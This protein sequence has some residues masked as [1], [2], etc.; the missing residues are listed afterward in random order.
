MYYVY[1]IR[2]ISHPLEKYVG[3]TENL[4]ARIGKHNEGGSPHT[5]SHRPW[6]P[7]A[8]LAFEE[9]STAMAF[10][11]YLKTGSGRAFAEKRLWNKTA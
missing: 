1:L 8:Y 6:K 9:K 7:A 5:S 4:Q 10:E 3:Y 2:S 11:K